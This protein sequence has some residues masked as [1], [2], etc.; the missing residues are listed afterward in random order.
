MDG[1]LRCRLLRKKNLFATATP[2]F[3]LYN[4][5]G[6]KFILAAKKRLKSK[7]ANYLISTSEVDLEKDG[8]HYIGKLKYEIWIFIL[9]FSYFFILLYF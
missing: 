4:E 5:V 1:I 9:F 7:C 6:N 8:T 2:S 3:F